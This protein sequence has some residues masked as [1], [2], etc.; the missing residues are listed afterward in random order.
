MSVYVGDDDIQGQG[1]YNEESSRKNK[2]GKQASIKSEI[3]FR[4]Y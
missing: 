1:T 2:A 3:Q 4:R